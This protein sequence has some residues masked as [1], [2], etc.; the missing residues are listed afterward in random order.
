[1]E[2]KAKHI[3]KKGANLDSA[4]EMYSFDRSLRV[5]IMREL[6][7]IE[8]SIRAKMIY[9]LSHEYSPLWYSDSKL[10]PNQ[11]KHKDTLGKIEVEYMRSKEEFIIQF[12]KKYDDLFPPSWIMLEICSFGSLSNLYSNLMNG[13]PKKMVSNYFGLAPIVLES[14]MHCIV[15][16]RN[17]CAHHSRLWNNNLQISPIVPRRIWKPW[18]TNQKVVNNRTYYIMS[19]LLYL[20]QTIN[21]QNTFAKRFRDLSES[22]PNIDLNAMGFPTNWEEETLW[23]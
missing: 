16:L 20:L 2:D 23:R 22:Y 5:L 12:R 15:Y 3:F 4:F 6:E 8:I 18:L 17:M 7:K 1:M 19:I 10:Y 9:I 14:W 11:S 13:N 21:P